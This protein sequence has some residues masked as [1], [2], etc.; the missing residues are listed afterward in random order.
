MGSA[1]LQPRCEV[2]SSGQELQRTAAAGDEKPLLADQTL[3]LIWTVDL[4]KLLAPSWL[5][6]R[7]PRIKANLVSRVESCF[8]VG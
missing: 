7:L 5:R 4:F 3:W 6:P 1:V 2:T 8:T